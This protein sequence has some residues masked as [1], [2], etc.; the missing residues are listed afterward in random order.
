MV[1]VT[2]RCGRPSISS[3]SSYT[4]I[5]LAA[6]KSL[7][8][9]TDLEAIFAIEPALKRVLRYDRDAGNDPTVVE[10]PDEIAFHYKFTD[11]DGV[12]TEGT[13]VDIV[14]EAERRGGAATAPSSN[15][16][17]RV[18]KIWADF[19][20]G[21][22]DLEIVYKTKFYDETGALIGSSE[23]TFSGVT[24]QW[25]NLCLVGGASMRFTPYQAPY[26][27]ILPYVLPPGAAH[28]IYIEMWEDDWLIDDFIGADNV[29]V[30]DYV[31]RH[32]S[33]CTGSSDQC[34][35]T[36]FDYQTISS[37]TLDSVTLPPLVA[38]IGEG[39]Q[40]ATPKLFDQYGFGLLTTGYSATGW[41]TANSSIAT[42]SGVGGVYGDV[43]PVA[44]GTTSYHATIGGIY[45][46]ASVTVQECE[47][48]H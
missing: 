31:A 16:Y 3:R 1:V 36:D 2:L 20:D 15:G 14:R 34:G 27:T 8:R 40:S 41:G 4:S 21:G 6:P 47:E 24:A 9:L 10:G 12:V 28:R 45:T 17:T 29:Y 42:A 11:A 38:E 37:S 7:D 30:G 5:P 23:S 43:A 22:G 48:C 35:Q 46:S 18:K 32:G 25:D 39:S 19:C 26:P 44:E 33:P 13:Y